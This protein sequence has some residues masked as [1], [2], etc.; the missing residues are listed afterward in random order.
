MYPRTILNRLVDKS[1]TA[2]KT[3]LIPGIILQ[4][5]ALMLVC[6]YYY[7]PAVNQF[8]QQIADTKTKFGYLFSGV[9]TAVFGGLIPYLYL[10]KTKKISQKA[11][12]AQG[13]F[14]LLFWFYKG[15]EVDALYRFQAWI[16]GTE[17]DAKTIIKKVLFDQLVYNFIYAAA[18]MTLL[19][20]WKDNDFSFHKFKKGLNRELF[21]LTIPAVLVST[22]IVWFP[23]TAII[24]SLPAALQVPLF[25]IVL[26][27]FV[28]LVSVLCNDKAT[29]PKR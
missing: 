13:V 17:I 24:Y 2:I 18:C 22:W 23:A 15:I 27:F 3:N 10:L 28:L 16:F 25:N 6:S 5:F 8:C 26:C 19:Y 20:H 21:T 4:I 1:I 7:I 12:I 29:E 9:S 14:Y 11:I